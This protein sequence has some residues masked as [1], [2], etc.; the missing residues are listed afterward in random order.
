MSS[1]CLL[2]TKTPGEDPER[3]AAKSHCQPYADEYHQRDPTNSAA[4][5]CRCRVYVTLVGRNEIL[6]KEISLAVNGV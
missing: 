2:R 6:T 4:G 3:N 1:S 5:M